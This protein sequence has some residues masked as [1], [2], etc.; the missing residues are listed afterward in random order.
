MLIFQIA[1]FTC[2]CAVG[3]TG[4]LCDLDID[5]CEPSPCVHSPANGCSNLVGNFSCSC[6]QGYTGK[7]NMS[8]ITRK[9][10]FRVFNKVRHKPGCTATKDG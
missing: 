6:L 4:L 5:E 2:D 3:F 9:P 10:V 1:G 7:D 8:R